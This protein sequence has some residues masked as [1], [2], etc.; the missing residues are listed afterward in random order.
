[1][2]RVLAIG[3]MIVMMMS[4][5]ITAFAAPGSFDKSPS[6]NKAPV[7]EE[8]KPE[9][10][11]CTAELVVTPYAERNELPA[12]LKDQIEKAY[13][14]IAS[15][16][17]LTKL[18]SDLAAVA[19]G[20]NILGNKLAVS[21]LFD[22]HVSGCTA[23]E[24]HVNFNITL[25]AD[26]L[27]RFVGLLHMNK[28]GSWELVKNA[29][30]V[31]GGKALN[32]SMNGFTPYAI[33]VDTTGNTPATGDNSNVLPYIILMAASAVGFVVVLVVSKKKKTF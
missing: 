28:D 6:G 20:K 18:N 13:S 3:L 33:V 24:D 14:A 23:H 22:V 21:D 11:E 4:V 25:G 32:F 9:S 30:V 7:V 27:N 12:D 29:K 15:T 31:N 10:E 19:A 17:D 26:T 8:F 5:S 1:M 2:K 16:D